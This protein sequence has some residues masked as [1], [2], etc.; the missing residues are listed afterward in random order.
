V[1]STP[2]A[3]LAVAMTVGILLTVAL[4]SLNAWEWH[5]IDAAFPRT[6]SDT[7]VVAVGSSIPLGSVALTSLLQ[8]LI[9]ASLV[10]VPGASA[11]KRLS[12]RASTRLITAA[13]VVVLSSVA[14]C[15]FRTIHSLAPLAVFLA[16][17]GLIGLA[18]IG[19][20]LWVLPPNTSLERT[21]A[22]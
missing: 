7:A 16:I 21:R 12:P 11:A 13:V 10:V 18:G 4:A 17:G 22:G 3:I 19:V 2:V 1:R 20:A 14:F 8:G 5:E 15:G 6:G 9:W